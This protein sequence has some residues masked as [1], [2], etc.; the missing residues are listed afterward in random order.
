MYEVGAATLPAYAM[1]T[2]G[3]GGALSNTHRV[4]PGSPCR[5]SRV[6]RWA[7]TS[8]TSLVLW[9]LSGKRIPVYALSRDR[10]N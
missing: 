5:R 2:V 7:E 9:G 8:W 1:R 10:E 6:I 3:A 4:W